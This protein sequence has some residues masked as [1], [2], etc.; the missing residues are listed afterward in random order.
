MP[1]R[2]RGVV[3]DARCSSI[4]RCV[5]RKERREKKAGDEEFN[6]RILRT[7]SHSAR[8]A[9]PSKEKPADDRKVLMPPKSMSAS[10]ATR[11]WR[12]NRLP[13]RQSPDED[14]QETSRAGAEEKREEPSDHRGCPDREKEV[15]FGITRHWMYFRYGRRTQRSSRTS[16]RMI[17]SASSADGR[18]LGLPFVPKSTITPLARPPPSS[19]FEP[20]FPLGRAIP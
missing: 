6:E 18:T 16:R 12:H 13:R 9:S 11:W 1:P 10:R 15:E 8:T 4:K 2:A 14:I 17:G 3:K 19:S 20:L 5:K 7:D